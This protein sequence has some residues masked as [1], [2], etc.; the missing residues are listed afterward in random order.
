MSRSC[1]QATRLLALAAGGDLS[2]EA[3]L[4]L[5][6]HLAGCAACWQARRSLRE[7][8]EMLRS[9]DSASFSDEERANVRQEVWRVIERKRRSDASL[10][11]WH[12][13]A[14]PLAAA[15]VL[16]A[17]IVTGRHESG[18][19]RPLPSRAQLP[20]RA[21]TE[22]TAP[23]PPVFAASSALRPESRRLAASHRRRLPVPASAPVPA[24]LEMATPDPDVR[25]I[26]LFD[27]GD[28]AT[29][30]TADAIPPEEVS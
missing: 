8:T 10:P 22:L 19:P 24:R 15:A 18:R 7:T 3:E 23:T 27:T 25:I 20:L 4:R 29:E 11:G 2:A 26:W 1:R 9:A 5:K 13:A 6:G 30:A 12:L 21:V 28:A 14:A 17:L 16:L